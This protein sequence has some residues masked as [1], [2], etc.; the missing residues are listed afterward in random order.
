MADSQ[1][2]ELQGSVT[3]VNSQVLPLGEGLMPLMVKASDFSV[4][5]TLLSLR[6]LF[7]EPVP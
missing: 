3:G 4:L 7:G 6:Q 5:P 1:H 2:V